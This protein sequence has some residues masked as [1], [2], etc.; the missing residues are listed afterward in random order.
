M[1]K[2]IGVT[3]FLYAVVGSCFSD[4]LA[5][6]RTDTMR[7]WDSA[8]RGSS[9]LRAAL[10]RNLTSEIAATDGEYM[11]TALSDFE[12]FYDF[13]EWDIVL[14]VAEAEQFPLRLLGLL[15][16]MHSAPRLF[17]VGNAASRWVQPDNSLVAGCFSGVDLAKL[18]FYAVLDQA[19]RQHRP[20]ILGQHVDDAALGV[21]CKSRTGSFAAVRAAP[22]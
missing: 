21:V 8:V 15:F 13:L 12:T 16:L 10:L 2:A 1:E 6:W 11:V 5:H 3:P 20:E 14:D 17:L 9:S 4:V 19:H 18:L 7:F 22:R